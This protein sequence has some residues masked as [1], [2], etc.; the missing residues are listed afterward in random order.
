MSKVITAPNHTLCVGDFFTMPTPARW[1]LLVR[2]AA[3]L[4]GCHLPAELEPEYVV[5]HV[6]DR[7]S[8]EI[9]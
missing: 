8:F 6:L 4:T 5:T 3:W 1:P 7:D 2:V 9:A